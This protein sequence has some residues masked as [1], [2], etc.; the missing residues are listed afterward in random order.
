MSTMLFILF[1]FEIM[2]T[3]LAIVQE[4][5]SSGQGVVDGTKI[6]GSG[7]DERANKSQRENGE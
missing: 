6:N 3:L 5:V 4:E 2:L 1:T 7:I